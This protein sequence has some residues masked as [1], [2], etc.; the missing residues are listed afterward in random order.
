M[1]VGCSWDLPYPGEREG[2]GEGGEAWD[3]TTRVLADPVAEGNGHVHALH[4]PADENLQR[5]RERGRRW[6][7]YKNLEE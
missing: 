3:L 6:Y 7:V 1:Q 4:R 5:R 2:G